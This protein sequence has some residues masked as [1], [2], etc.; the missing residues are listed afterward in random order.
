[1]RTELDHLPLAKRRELDRVVQILFEEFDDAHGK[2]DGQRKLG[3]ILKVILYG[4]YARGNWVDEPHTAKAY[5]SDFDLLVIV[6]QKE[7]TDR[8]AYW[9][10][11]DERLN[12]ERTITQNLKTPVNFIV[13]SLQEVNDGL[14][15]GRSFFID[16]ARDGIALYQAEDSELHQPKP[17]T[18]DDRNVILELKGYLGAF[19]AGQQMIEDPHRLQ[20]KAEI[21]SR[22]AV[23]GRFCL[24]IHQISP[25]CQRCCSSR[26]TRSSDDGLE[27]HL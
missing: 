10:K 25:P 16:V 15:H 13:H 17:K 3:R 27:Q 14:A 20:G 22:R 18:P 8:V 2:P 4:S 5:Q 11:A 21:L 19:G 1:M 7:L 23:L 26:G 24:G 12:R 6:N 9:E